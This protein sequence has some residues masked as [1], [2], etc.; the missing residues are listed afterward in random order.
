MTLIDVI[1]LVVVLV[2]VVVLLAFSYRKF[3]FLSSLDTVELQKLDE[4]SRKEDMVTRRLKRKVVAFAR[5][6]KRYMKPVGTKVEQQVRSWRQ[7]IE[8]KETEYRAR[9]LAQQVKTD[10]DSVGTV[11]T[12]LAEAERLHAEGDYE[13]AEQR[14]VMVVG[15][16]PQVPSAYVG[17][18]K[19]YLEKKDYG[20]AEEALRHALRLDATNE[21]VALALVDVCRLTGKSDQALALCQQAVQHAPN[22]PKALH[23]L[24]ELSL[25]LRDKHAATTALQALAEANPENQRLDELREQVKALM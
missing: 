22:S 10:P 17:L 11:Q 3:P 9:I 8:R 7:G 25:E 15:V 2:G 20:Q 1:L 16:A 5:E 12:L 13:Q 6:A 4:T 19:L 14:Y 18:G 21:D 23:V 24:V